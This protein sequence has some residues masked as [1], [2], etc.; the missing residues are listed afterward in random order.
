MA[1]ETSLDALLADSPLADLDPVWGGG[2]IKPEA[3][4]RSVYASLEAE[5]K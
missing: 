4:L 5:R 1:A 3:F 2:F